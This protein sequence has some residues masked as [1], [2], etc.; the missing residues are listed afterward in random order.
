VESASPYFHL[1]NNPEE[2]LSLLAKRDREI[3]RLQVHILNENKKLYLSKSE[4]TAAG[5]AAQIN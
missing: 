3:E 2:L 1:R 5:D 4:R